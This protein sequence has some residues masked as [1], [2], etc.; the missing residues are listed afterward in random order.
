MY[1]NFS[2]IIILGVLLSVGSLAGLLAEKVNLPR[3]VAYILIGAIFS[4]SIL[5]DI[6]HFSTASWS[7][8]LTNIALAII[9]YIIG[10]EVDI[11]SL[12][13]QK[14]TIMAAVLG[15]SL[16]AI[17]F[18]ALG[19]WILGSAFGFL[20]E[21]D[22]TLALIIG[23]IA[24]A[25]APAASLG[26]IE[27]YG[28]KGKMTNTLLGVIAI[29]DAIGVILFTLVL[30]TVTEGGFSSS[31]M[32]GLKEIGGAL[33]LGSI[34]GVLLGYLGNRLKKEELRLVTILGFILLVLG[35]SELFAFSM[36]LSCMSLGFVSVMFYPKK[37]AEWILPLKHIEELVFIFFFTLAGTHFELQIMFSSALLVFTYVILRIAGKYTGSYIGMLVGGAAEQPRRLL[38]LCLFPQAGVAIGLAIRASDQPGMQEIAPLLLNIILGSTII[39][40]LT[41]PFFTRFALKKA[42]E[43]EGNK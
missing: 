41:A 1:E 3:V 23:T 13:K 28:A 11:Q 16:G 7:P 36:L 43:I 21:I 10:S 4:P 15:Q 17:I 5:G 14:N 19:L 25:T 22:F 39:F 26:I 30:G 29:D 6:L 38:G 35:L 2:P 24:T 9:A 18:V 8:F 20:K 12:K 32:E 37:H 40:E 27:E 34:F 33:L 31:L 42:G